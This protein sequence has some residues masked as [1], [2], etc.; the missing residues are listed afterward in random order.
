M[1]LW[2]GHG[3]GIW[4]SQLDFWGDLISL[5]KEQKNSTAQLYYMLY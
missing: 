4:S 5:D 3:L 1:K 2:D